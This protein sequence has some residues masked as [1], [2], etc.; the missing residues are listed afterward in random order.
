MCEANVYVKK[1][2]REELLMEQVDIIEP[3]EGGLRLIDIFGKQ[4]L[5][6]AIIKD[7]SLLNHRIVL[8]EL[9]KISDA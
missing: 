8:E 5:I 1:G 6:D 4:K 3:V 9:S 2:N 7:M